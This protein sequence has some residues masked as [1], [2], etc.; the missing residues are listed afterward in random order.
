MNN[1][2]AKNRKEERG[3][4]PELTPF[5]I[6]IIL[7][8]LSAFG[9]YQYYDKELRFSF[10]YSK[11]LEWLCSSAEWFANNVYGIE[12][13]YT[14]RTSTTKITELGTTDGAKILVDF[15]DGLVLTVSLLCAI[16]FWPSNIIKKLIAIGV[17]TTAMA[18]ANVARIAGALWVDV[19]WPLQFQ[20]GSQLITSAYIALAF[21]FFLAWMKFSGRHPMSDPLRKL[22]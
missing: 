13:T 16:F 7:T 9:F 17:V 19:H 21:L 1:D 14:Q 5:F 8:G 22:W 10:D 20:L 2:A 15:S 12:R 18:G 4:S 6:Y 11:Y 3:S